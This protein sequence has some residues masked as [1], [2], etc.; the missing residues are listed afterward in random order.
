[1]NKTTKSRA[2]R[3]S[4]ETA[5][6]RGLAMIVVACCAT[7]GTVPA[8]A[9]RCDGPP[10][11]TAR[12]AER[13][14]PWNFCVNITK[15]ADGRW[16]LED[17]RKTVDIEVPARHK[18]NIIFQMDPDLHPDAWIAAVRIRKKDGANPP[19]GEFVSGDPPHDFGAESDKIVLPGRRIIYKVRDDNQIKENYD[20]EVW[21]GTT[22]GSGD[23]A[24]DT[25]IR[26]GGNQN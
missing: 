16:V 26:N 5:S 20:Y 19:A 7:L 17:D 24:V 3:G 10:S 18:A 21:I 8:L 13:A 6:R 9:E 23:T 15:D 11:A 14:T 25:G 4:R 1:M 22:G 12:A 2:D